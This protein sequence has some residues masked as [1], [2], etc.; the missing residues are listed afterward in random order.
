MIRLEA[1]NYNMALTVKQQKYNQI[2]DELRGTCNS[3]S[4][5]RFRISILKWSLCNYIDAY[6]A[7]EGNIKVL[8]TETTSA[9]NVRDKVVVFKNV[10]HSLIA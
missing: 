1:K 6:I 9:A 8:N 10:H 2:N 7:V 5:I 4:Q 3:N